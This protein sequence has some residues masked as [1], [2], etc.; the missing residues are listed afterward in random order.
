MDFRF[1]EEAE[2]FR[3]E[4]RAFLAEAMRDAHDHADPLDLTGLAEEF[5]RDLHRRAGALGWLG[6][7]GEQRAVFEFEVAR[8]DAPLIDTAM[9]LAG[10]VMARHK[11]ELL[12]PMQAGE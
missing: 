2:A 8:A 12:A 5:E 10:E 6:L 4:V 11:P 1:S 7:R 3:L 9:T